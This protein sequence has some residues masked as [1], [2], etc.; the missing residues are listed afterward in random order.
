MV[1]IHDMLQHESL[2]K[3]RRCDELINTLEETTQKAL[4]HAGELLERVQLGS[5]SKLFAS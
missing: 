1:S 3:S 2:S 5:E 4:A